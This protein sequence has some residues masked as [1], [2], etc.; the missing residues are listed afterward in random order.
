MISEMTEEEIKLINRAIDNYYNNPKRPKKS[1]IIGYF[2][3]YLYKLEGEGVALYIKN[4]IDNDDIARHILDNSGLNHRSSGYSG[5]G[6]NCGDM[7]TDKLVVIFNK[8]LAIDSNYAL[9][10]VKMVLHMKTL[11]ATEF[12]ESFKRLAARGFNFE[13][14]CVSDSN[15]SFDGVYGEDRHAV[16]MASIFSVLGSNTSQEYE[17]MGAENLKRSFIY[18]ISNVL[19][20]I[21]PDVYASFTRRSRRRKY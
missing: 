3:T 9:S 13:T 5:R 20:K 7:N 15:I 16:A 6:L 19:D 12:I 10:F 18:Q 21:D 14:L 4:N 8:L 1:S 17:I 2:T 11:G